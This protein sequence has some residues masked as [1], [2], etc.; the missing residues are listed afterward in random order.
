MR[1]FLADLQQELV[2]H[3]DQHAGAVAGIDLGA[4]SAAVIQIGQDLETLLAGSC[5][6]CGL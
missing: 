4:A 3:L 2:R 5:A 1:A 6:I